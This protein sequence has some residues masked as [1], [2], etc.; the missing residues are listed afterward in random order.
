MGFWNNCS[1]RT[2]DVEILRSESRAGLLATSL[3]PRCIYSFSSLERLSIGYT[4]GTHMV[5]AESFFSLRVSKRLKQLNLRDFDL[6]GAYGP[7]SRTLTYFT[8]TI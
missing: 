3:D 6:T 8:W 5:L 4:K 7:M 2:L 1:V